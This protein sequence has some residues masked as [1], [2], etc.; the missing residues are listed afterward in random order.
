MSRTSLVVLAGI[1]V[2]FLATAIISNVPNAGALPVFTIPQ[3]GTGTST[4]PTYGKVFVGNSGGTWD[5]VATSSLG[6]T[7]TGDGNSV[8]T[9]S[10]PTIGHIPY[11]TTSGATP[12]LLGSVAT[13]TLS[14]TSPIAVSGARAVIG[15]TADIS[16]ATCVVTTRALTIAGT[17]QQIT[18][19]AGSQDLS[20][21]RTWTLSLP[22]HVIF[23]S[24]FQATLSSTTNA[25][26]TSLFV[27]DLTSALA[28]FDST[29]R[30][31]E[32][33]GTSC[34]NQFV[35][36]LSAAAVATCAT[37]QSEDINLGDTFAW[38]GAHDF[39]GATDFEIP[40][41]TAPTV[42]ATGE[43]ALDT[44]ETQLVFYDGIAARAISAT[45]TKSFNIASTSLDAMGLK[46]S[47][48]TSTFQL[49]NDPRPL[50]L[51]GF[52]CIASSTGTA[53]VDFG[54]GT[55]FTETGVCTTGSYTRT[56]TNNTF[57]S[58]E[59]FIVRASSTAPNKVSRI[60][61]TAVFQET[62]Q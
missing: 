6:I 10:V 55:N 11:W 5:Y 35:R 12:E 18:S 58:F 43:F 54:D 2:I 3:G 50:T 57:T 36:S 28:L 51:L 44:S 40:N 52:W 59:N 37:V 53:H 47:S 15:G 8:S 7:G 9:S 61:V 62:R 26:T 45:S 22:N 14:A 42:N 38:T 24:S 16:C 56:T 48:G 1:F 21:D 34:T 27:T 60:T 23:P 32:Y 4:A 17:S 33:A 31:T 39:G 41:G 30:A 29:S 13:G 19:S 46:F 20:A 25:T 49:M